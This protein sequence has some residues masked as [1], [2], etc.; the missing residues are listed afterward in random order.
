VAEELDQ[1]MADEWKLK[2]YPYEDGFEIAGNRRTSKS[3][4]RF[5]LL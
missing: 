3:W 1:T 4:L 2:A 5:A